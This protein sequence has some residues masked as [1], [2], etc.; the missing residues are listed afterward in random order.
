MQ[1]KHF[2]RGISMAVVAVLFSACADRESAL[3]S[4]HLEVVNPPQ[5]ASALT[6]KTELSAP[7]TVSAEIGRKGGWLQIPQ[8]GFALYV[9]ERVLKKNVRFSVTALPGKVVAFEFEPHG[10]Q[11]P[12]PLYIVQSL[13]SVDVSGKDISKFE[14]AYFANSSQVNQADQTAIINE[15][16]PIFFEADH[17][18]FYAPIKHFS[19]YLISTGRQGIALQ[20]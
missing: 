10:M 1:I 3:L 14:V 12:D 9:P 4:P 19:G 5:K 20:D 18:V 15:F 16:L 2:C 11:F 6:K 7:I 8:V 13:D 17:K